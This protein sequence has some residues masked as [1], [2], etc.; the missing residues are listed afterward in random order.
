M[1]PAKP[2]ILIVDDE[3]GLAE[4]LRDVMRD[5]GYDVSLAMNGLQ[6]LERLGEKRVDLVLTDM[7]MPVMDGAE[8]V[9]T[10]RLDDKYQATPVIVMTSLPRIK[11]EVAAMVS[12]I[13]RKPFTPDVLLDAI[14]A[15]LED[16]GD[17]GS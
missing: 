5:S 10:M 7:M 1:A 6:A 11:P 2:S 14:V 12:A 4:M 8:L 3:F 13:L 17:N 15:C 16:V 9:T